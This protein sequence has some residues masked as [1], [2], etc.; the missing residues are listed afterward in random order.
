MAIIVEGGRKILP[1][2]YF[3]QIITRT[4]FFGVRPALRIMSV[5]VLFI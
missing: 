4:A 2:S 1:P 3:S 5:A